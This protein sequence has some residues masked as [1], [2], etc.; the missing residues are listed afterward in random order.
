VTLHIVKPKTAAQMSTQTTLDTIEVSPDQIKS[1][2]VPPFQRPLR[3][4]DKVMQLASKIRDDGGV[5]PGVM[6]LGVLNK[7]RYVVDGQHRREAFLLS[8]CLT[9]YVDIRVL[10]FEDMAQMGEEYVN[11]NSRLVNMRPD[12]VLR[13]IE[14]TFPALGRI[15]KRCPF[16][17]Y[18]NIRRSEKSPVLSMSALLR[19]WAASSTEVPRSSCGSALS[20]ARTLSSEEAD[21][22]MDFLGLAYSAWGRDSAYA[23]LWSNL[24]LT[25]C[26]WLYRR[27]VITPYSPNTPRLTKDQF[28][29]CMMSLSTDQ[30][31][32]WLV[33][34][35]NAQRDASPAY[36]RI[37]SAFA[38]RLEIET[39]KKPRLP[40]PAWAS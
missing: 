22:C 21:T 29:K 10:H 32:D 11:I 27:L 20:L 39:G 18:D 13:G 26:M 23:R 35:N 3:I 37:K 30:Y 1:W 2:K 14:D 12:D 28:T 25:L 40:Q 15:R 38:K 17:G 34:R 16:V 31:P 19:C 4:N 8:E 6:V 36:S 9:G 24:N 33:G 7:E 5:I